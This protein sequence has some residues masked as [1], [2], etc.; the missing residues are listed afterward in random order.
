MDECE[1]KGK[2]KAKSKDSDS[3][4]SEYNR[5]QEIKARTRWEDRTFMSADTVH[6]FGRSTLNFRKMLGW[7][8]FMENFGMLLQ[9]IYDVETA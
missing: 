6:C 4:P 7:T 2:K 3:M 8:L 1:A 5:C 9:C